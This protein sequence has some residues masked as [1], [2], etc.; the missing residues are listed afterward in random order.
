VQIQSRE[1][2]QDGSVWDV[3]R[4]M[5]VGPTAPVCVP[6]QA[7][8]PVQSYPQPGSMQ[9]TPAAFPPAYPVGTPMPVV[10]PLPAPQ[11]VPVP[12]NSFS[13]APAA[14][15]PVPVVSYRVQLSQLEGLG[16]IPTQPPMT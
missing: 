3:Q 14:L 7:S 5:V 9:F 13:V 16:L 2:M 11:C 1:T 8:Y 6:V 10:T 15:R 12:I 4:V